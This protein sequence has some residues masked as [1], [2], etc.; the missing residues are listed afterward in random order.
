M[1]TRLENHF[2]VDKFETST[3]DASLFDHEAH[4]YVA[5]LYLQTFERDEA[6]RRFDAALRRF[7][8]KIG[9]ASKYNAMITWLFL[10]LIVE[11]AR[12][13]ETWPAFRARN[14]DLID[15][16]PRAA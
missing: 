11:R 4:V 1:T 12:D 9:A 2:T 3:V 7:A 6:F 16:L 14:A 10:K 15:E 5:W 8:G 13:G